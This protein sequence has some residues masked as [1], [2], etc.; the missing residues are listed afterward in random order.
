MSGAIVLEPHADDAVLFSCFNL[1]RYQAH[2][3]T[4]LASQLQWDRGAEITN[5]HRVLEGHRAITET[6]RLRMPDQWPYPDSNPNP[7]W[8][9]ITRALTSLDER[10]EPD[11]VFAPAPADDGHEQHNEVG[12]IAGAVFGPR[13]VHYLTYTR[14]GGKQRGGVEVG[15]K[16]AWLTLKLRALACYRSQIETEQLGCWPHF[17]EDLREYVSA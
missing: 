7:D 17:A 16:P 1:I 11:I 12:R 6:L 5:H 8:G 15:F 9:A 3:V 14:H 4:V 10:L 13:A 2:V